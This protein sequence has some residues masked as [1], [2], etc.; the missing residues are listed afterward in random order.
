MLST[1]DMRAVTFAD[2]HR[3]KKK[4]DRLAENKKLK[5]KERIRFLFE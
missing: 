1:C 3:K 5:N 2:I 4:Y